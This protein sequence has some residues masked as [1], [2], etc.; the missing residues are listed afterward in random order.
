MD[1]RHTMRYLQQM[2]RLS[3]ILISFWLIGLLYLITVP[4]YE[5]P[6][7]LYHVGMVNRLATVGSL[8]VQQVGITT[9]WQQE[10]SQPP[11]YYQL[12]AVGYNLFDTSNFAETR[13]KNP[14]AIVGDPYALYNQNRFVQLSGYPAPFT[15][16]TGAIYFMRLLSLSLGT[17]TL[18]AVWNASLTLM[19]THKSLAFIVT[20]LVAFNPQFLFI[21]A[22]VNNDNLVTMFNSLIIWQ[23]LRMLRYGFDTRH[24]L[25]IAILIALATLSKLS[26]LVMVPTVAFVGLWVGY[27]RRDFAGLFTLGALMASVWAFLSGWWYLRNIIL[28]GELFGT[29]MM[30]DVFGRRPA[31]PFDVLIREEFGGLRQSYW[32]VF[33]WFNIGL[34]PIF[35]TIMD[36]VVIIALI[37]WVIL[38]ARASWRIRAR[39]FW[40]GV[41]I[42]I[43]WFSLATW[44]SQTAASQGRLMFPYSLSTMLIIGGGLWMWRIDNFRLAY[45]ILGALG[46][47][48]FVIPL[49]VI[50]PTY[51]PPMPLAQLPES[52]TPF[53]IRYQQIELL[54]FETEN[55]IYKPHDVV[56]I[57]LYWRPLE[58]TTTPYSAFAN[59]VNPNDGFI[60]GVANSYP[61]DGMQNTMTW[62]A[63]QIYAQNLYPKLEGWLRNA[64]DM[65][66]YVGWWDNPL[67]GGDGIPMTDG[68]GN[69]IGVVSIPVGAIIADNRT[70][71][72]PTNMLDNAIWANGLQLIGYDYVDENLRLVWQMGDE[73]MPPNLRV[74]VQRLDADTLEVRAGGDAPPTLNT[75][76]WQLGDTY[77]TSHT[78]PLSESDDTSMYIGWYDTETGIRLPIDSPLQAYQLQ[79]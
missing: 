27:R 77:I 8:P 70:I 51:A 73:A 56:P 16:T 45:P 17:I 79:P 72:P 76:F 28:Y 1:N 50:Y 53:Y 43:G 46:I 57:T 35:Y 9:D 52:A 42:F 37:G 7:E 30:L 71:E 2:H 26:G 47:T 62:E 11:L 67:G 34:E 13:I 4:P 48:A 25:L 23:T 18:W 6:D 33:G 49:T 69:T 40:L 12:M 5:S 38:I 24:S 78:L 39:Y 74:F 55:A 15:G 58:A 66:A 19:P 41:I 32:G 36:I 60:L 3:T 63:N 20:A 21:S 65:V 31:P 22:S 59:L 61:G 29:E 75:R 64:D 10:G 54:G 44:T 68:Q 14:H